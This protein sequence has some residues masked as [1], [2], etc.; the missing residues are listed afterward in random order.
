MTSP[1]PR[2]LRRLL[3]GHDV[4][5][6]QELG[7]PGI[8]NGELLRR[9]SEF[10]VFVTADRGIEHQQNLASFGIGVVLLAASSNRLETYQPLSDEL[11]AAV[12]AVRPG[13]L[14]KVAA[15]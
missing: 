9:A 5:T 15:G 6:I 13:E 2:G 14:I 4:V 8:E 3:P 7:W 1:F 12:A 11:A 10:A